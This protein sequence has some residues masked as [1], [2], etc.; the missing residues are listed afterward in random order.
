MFI[1]GSCVATINETW[2]PFYLLVNEES[3]LTRFEFTR[4]FAFHLLVQFPRKKRMSL[5]RKKR[6]QE[7]DTA[8]I[9]AE[10]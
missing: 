1:W 3:E 7:I 10:K 6:I 8:P 2:M 9:Q 5:P 4:S